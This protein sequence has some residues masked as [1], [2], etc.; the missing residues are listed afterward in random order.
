MSQDGYAVTMCH[1]VIMVYIVEIMCGMSH[2][3][4]VYLYSSTDSGCPLR[5]FFNLIAAACGLSE[6]VSRGERLPDGFGTGLISQ[7]P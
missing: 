4:R 7:R 1:I 5:M 6:Y 3:V 2:G